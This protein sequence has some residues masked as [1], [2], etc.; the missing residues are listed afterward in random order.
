MPFARS[1][2]ADEE[3]VASLGRLARFLAYA[4]S[5]AAAQPCTLRFERVTA[6]GPVVVDAWLLPRPDTLESFF[7]IVLAAVSAY[8]AAESHDD[9]G[10]NPL[11]FSLLERRSFEPIARLGLP[12]QNRLPLP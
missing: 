5:T 2:S 10:P 8:S 12:P 9:R 6:H 7:A 3:R 1:L 11:R 4:R